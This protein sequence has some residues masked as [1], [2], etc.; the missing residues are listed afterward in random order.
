MQSFRL[1][2]FSDMHLSGDPGERLRGVASLPA[3][4]A[5]IADT[6]RRCPRHDGVL[7]TGDLVQDDPAGYRWIRSAFGDST[8][9]VMAMA[10][11][12]DLPVHMRSMLA[13]RPFQVGGEVHFGR[14][15]VVLLDTWVEHSAAGRL[16][17]QQLAHLQ[18]VLTD[19]P[20][21]HVLLCLHHPPLVMRSHWLDKV[22]LEDAEQFLGLVRAHENVRGVVWGHVHQALDC[23]ISGVR[24]MASPSTCA[25]FLPESEHFAL[26]NR[27]PGYRILDLMP[28]GTIATEVVWLDSYAERSVA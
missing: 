24:F 16:G 28:D 9:P 22:G 4:H 26:D 1:I 7:L 19:H 11:N 21:H 6:Q 12:H 25:Q 10:G 2:Q 23:L 15:L 20:D 3:L 27:P 18:S 17:P 14:W 5:A 13:Q 8:V